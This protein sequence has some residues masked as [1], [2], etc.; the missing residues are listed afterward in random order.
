MVQYPLGLFP[1]QLTWPKYKDLYS[2]NIDLS[3]F[4]KTFALYLHDSWYGMQVIIFD[5]LYLF[6][7]RLYF[8]YLST[9]KEIL[10]LG[11]IP[12]KNGVLLI[13]IE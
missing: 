1:K 13:S 7:W 4:F 10:Q 3:H 8:T 5:T 9:D 12:Q 6:I 11:I 2:V